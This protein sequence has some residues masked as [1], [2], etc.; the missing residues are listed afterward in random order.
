MQRG[1]LRLG[2]RLRGI[3]VKRRG[4]ADQ[5][6]VVEERAAKRA[7]EEVVAEHKLL[8]HVPQA[9]GITAL[10]VMAHHQATRVGPGDKIVVF[11][12][13]DLHL[14]LI[15]HVPQV[16]GD[17]AQG[18]VFGVRALEGEGRVGQVFLELHFAGVGHPVDRLR[19]DLQHATPGRWQGGQRAA[20]AVALLGIGGGQRRQRLLHTR[21]ICKQVIEAAVLGIDHHHGF[22]LIVQ[23]LVQLLRRERTFHRFAR[24]F[25]GVAAGT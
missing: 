22:H 10:G 2:H 4:G 1:D 11:T 17:Q 12:A 5:V 16:A 20:V 3:R 6:L 14:V 18:Q 9:Q 21:E 24:R 8:G 19:P 25:A 7:L 15:E 23:C 13:V